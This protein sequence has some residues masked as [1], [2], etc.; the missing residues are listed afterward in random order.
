MLHKQQKKP[1]SFSALPLL[2]GAL[3]LFLYLPIVIL[4]LFSFN[5]S[6][7]LYTWSGFSLRWYRQL[8]STTEIWG[9]FLNSLI[10]AL[11][12]VTLSISL[13]TL[14]VYGAHKYIKRIMGL[15]YGSIL[16]PEI[17][18]A[19]S[20]LGFFSYTAVPLGLTTL[21]IGHTILGLGFVIPII[22]AQFEQLDKSVPLAGLDLGAS[23]VQIFFYIILPF[24]FPAILAA[25]L[26]VLIISFDD[27]L[28]SF[29]CAG[30]TTQTLSLYIFAMIRSGISPTVNALSTLILL[31]SSLI[32][33]MFTSS[34]IRLFDRM[35]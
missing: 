9:A 16:L 15:F 29:F 34:R 35:L 17:V 22:Y 33:L 32:V 11:S 24:L 13:G 14:V 4:I 19:V 3:Y 6:D 2:V 26:L 1:V 10:V 31:G 30:S 18:L 5:A 27:F 20:L 12:S 25:S 21:V 7:A 8:F 28:I 23:N